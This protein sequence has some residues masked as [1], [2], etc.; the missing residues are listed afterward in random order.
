MLPSGNVILIILCAFLFIVFSLL[1][2]LFYLL[3]V[4]SVIYGNK[5]TQISSLKGRYLRV[6]TFVSFTDSSLCQQ[7]PQLL[8]TEL[9]GFLT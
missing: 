4:L 7:S 1:T 5:K 3:V 2:K 9:L 8:L 6:T